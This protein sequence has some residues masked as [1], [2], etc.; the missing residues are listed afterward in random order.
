MATAQSDTNTDAAV[1]PAVFGVLFERAPAPFL[2]IRVVPIR[3]D[4]VF[5]IAAVNDAYLLATGRSRDQM[6]G[7]PWLECFPDDSSLRR[8]FSTLSPDKTPQGAFWNALNTPLAGDDNKVEYLLHSLEAI[9]RER[10]PSE[11]DTFLV[12]LDDAT[13]SLADPDGIVRTASRLL[14][15][16]LQADRCA[17]CTFEADQET[18][19]VKSEY[20]RAGVPDLRGR[21]TMSQFG[22][23]AAQYLLAG[24]PYVVKDTESDSIPDDVRVT[25]RQTY[26]RAFAVI[27]LHKEGRMLAI[28]GLHQQVPRNWLQQEVELIRLVANRCWECIQRANVTRA[29]QINDQRLRLSQRTGRIGSFEWL[30][31][32]QRIIWTPEL[33][34][35][36]GL[37]E[38]TLKGNSDELRERVVAEDLQQV[39]RIMADHMARGE[40]ECS[41]ECRAIL[42]DG[43]LR[44]LG[45]HALLSYDETGAIDRITGV[46]IDIDAHKQTEAHLRESEQRLRAIFDGTYEYI[47][48]LAPDGTVLEANRAS[49]E[50]AGNVLSD[51][52][53]DRFWDTP[54]FSHTPHA[55]ETM[56]QAVER[57]AAGEFVRFEASLS[58][59]SGECLTFDISLHPIFN[60]NGAVVLI[61]PEGR[62]ITDRKEAEERLK[63]QWLTF[64]TVLSN[65]P[66]ITYTFDLEG[67]F[68]YANR[69]LIIASHRSLKDTVGRTPRELGYPP[70]LA[71]RIEGQVKQVIETKQ[72][73]RAETAFTLPGGEVRE[74]E[75]IY[76]P[77]LDEAGEVRAIAGAS[78]DITERRQ[79]EERLR[80]SEAQFRQLIDS[81]P[82]LV[83][84]STPDGRDDLYNKQWT[85]Y[86]GL[87]AEAAAGRGMA[88]HTPGR[89]SRRHGTLE[90]FARDRRTL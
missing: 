33:E 39:G 20:L 17:Y 32:E 70:A 66:D 73:V 47:C 57:A 74:Y 3:S 35:L 48:L 58:R 23:E 87:S 86:T 50:F 59:P 31:K 52:T 78:R 30:P 34:A 80:E 69:Q 38:G 88:D 28:M 41:Y 51:V 1:S 37:P 12:R 85:D 79:V 46:N 19:D 45:G 60:E 4:P 16:H 61:V 2:L 13:R 68:T 49:L 18:F 10:Q 90:A 82:Q 7:R 65:T 40:P 9:A 43:R 14:G 29:L 84:S 81:M 53:G 24:R 55:S 62:D 54:W 89:S 8:A 6:V 22:S 11:L 64:D 83:W 76:V 56:R 71:T 36:F 25:Y 72:N 67:R 15:E 42:P 63:Q 27:P 75:Y 44:W 26:V 5:T 77:V 21:F